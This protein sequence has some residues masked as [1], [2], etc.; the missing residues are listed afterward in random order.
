MYLT[1]RR[2]DTDTLYFVASSA[3]PYCSRRLDVEFRTKER[4]WPD[5][6]KRPSALR[7]ELPLHSF[8]TT[9]APRLL[10]NM[11]YSLTWI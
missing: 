5:A 8:Y 1:E 11:T 9:S 2:I 4:Q 7:S 3:L 6:G 10:V